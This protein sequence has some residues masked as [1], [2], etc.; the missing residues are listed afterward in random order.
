[1]D[2]TQVNQGLGVPHTA[3]LSAVWGPSNT[4]G[5]A[6][7]SYTTANAAIVPAVQGYW[8]SFIRTF[9][10]NTFRA[11]GSPEWEPFGATQKRILL[12]T[13]ATRMETVP[14]DQTARCEFLTSIAINL[15]Q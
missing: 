7:P 9:N 3:E 2:P 11:E 5:A 10:P 13:N 12:E 15:Q 1:M 6:P 8:T 14:Q 4:N